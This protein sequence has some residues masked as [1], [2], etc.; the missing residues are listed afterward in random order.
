MKVWKVF[1][2]AWVKEEVRTQAGKGGC[3]VVVDRIT[4]FEIKINVNL[5]FFRYKRGYTGCFMQCSKDRKK[6]L[7]THKSQCDWTNPNINEK[8]WE[9]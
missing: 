8:S 3:V 4:A 6:P 9:L 2:M 5:D 7:S 1:G